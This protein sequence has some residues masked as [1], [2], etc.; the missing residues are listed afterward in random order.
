[1]TGQKVA[2]GTDFRW[3][4]GQA[5]NYHRAYQYYANAGAVQDFFDP[6]ME[7]CNGNEPS[8]AELLKLVGSPQIGANAATQVYSAFVAG[9]VSYSNIA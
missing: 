7:M 5:T 9:P 8:I 3:V 1:M 2:N 6:R 4:G